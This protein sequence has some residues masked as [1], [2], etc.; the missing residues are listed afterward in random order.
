[1]GCVA[2][3]QALGYVSRFVFDEPGYGT[4]FSTFPSG[5]RC[6]FVVVVAIDEDGICLHFDVLKLH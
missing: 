3:G 1:M 6:G 5:S 2:I 4:Y